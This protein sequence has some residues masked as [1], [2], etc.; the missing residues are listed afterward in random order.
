MLSFKSVSNVTFTSGISSV[1]TPTVGACVWLGINTSYVGC[2]DSDVSSSS[3]RLIVAP[4][5]SSGISLLSIVV[6][7]IVLFSIIVF[8]SI[9]FSV[10]C[11]IS[12]W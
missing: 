6:F 3:G 7:S 1:A 11:Y 4:T 2:C 12:I 8:V 10:E 9:V 5:F